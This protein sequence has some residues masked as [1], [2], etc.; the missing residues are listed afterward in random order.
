VA[1]ADALETGMQ[2]KSE[3]FRTKREICVATVD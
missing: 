3:E 1:E 2:E